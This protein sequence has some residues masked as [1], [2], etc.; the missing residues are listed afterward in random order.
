MSD[1]HSNI[2]RRW[3]LALGRYAE[4]QMGGLSKSDVRMDRTLD[5]LYG[6]EYDKRGLHR[7]KG[8][9]TLDP[10][11]MKA[12]DWLGSARK[13]FPQSVFE[14][15]QDHA[16]NRYGLSDLL[17]DPKTLENLEPNQDLLKTLLS[18]HGRA[19][20][21]V[22][23][24]LRQVADAVIQDIMRR[25]KSD[26]QRAF[27][28]R[29]NPYKRSH[30]ASAANFD[31]RGTLRRNLKNYDPDTGRIIADDLRFVSRERRRLPWS[32]I[33]CVD[34]SGSMTD[35][36]I[37]SAVMAAILSGLPGVKVSMVLFDTSI[38][39]VTD[40]LT[41]PLDTLLSVQLGGGTDIGQAVEYSER[42]ID[43]PER[44]VF[45]LISDFAEGAS[46]RRLYR[47]V[48]RMNEAR[49]RM[50]GLSAL[51]DLGDPYMDAQIAGRLAGLGMKIAAMTPDKLAQWLA[52]V[53]E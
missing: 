2:Q 38:I 52:G 21:E 8:P 47:S 17:N 19:K 26:V 6:R 9:G 12:L 50:I 46:P 10:T 11:Q 39:D 31:W 15:L 18:F 33:L 22:K 1:D 16:L 27:S 43:T 53:M 30:V 36:I 5:Y 44:T 35:S 41:D 37:H 20:P 28:G 29:R 3:R 4:R 40:K 25:L 24:K 34:Q 23:D 32:V 48:A 14:V 45:V 7:P 13:L 49:V 42:Y 51:D